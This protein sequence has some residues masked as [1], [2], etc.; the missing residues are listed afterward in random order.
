VKTWIRSD[1]LVISEITNLMVKEKWNTKTVQCI[2][3]TGVWEEQK[4]AVKFNG[5]E[6][7]Q[8]MLDSTTTVK[9]VRESH[10]VKDGS[11]SVTEP[12]MKVNSKT[13]IFTDRVDSITL[14]LLVKE[15]SNGD[16]SEAELEALIGKL[17][18][19]EL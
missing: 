17:I 5:L 13:G 10:G 2:G 11:S 9:S 12:H 18:H 1:T 19:Y 14:V 4:D 15:T 6:L 7:I 8:L 3:V 16:H